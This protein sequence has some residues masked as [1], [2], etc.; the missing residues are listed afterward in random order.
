M[1]RYYDA[2]LAFI[3]DAGFSEWAERSAPGILAILT[4][5][6]IH[7]GLV[8]DLGC[9]PGVWARELS[10]N[11]FRV[12]GIDISEAM[13]EIA[14][15]R[16][17]EAEFRV[18]SFFS[19]KLPVCDAITS[20]SE[21]LN[22]VFDSNGRGGIGPVFDR[23]FK[24]LRPGGVFIFDLAEPGQVNAKRPPRNFSEGEGW[25]VLVEKHE[26]SKRSLL[27]RRIIAF[28]KSGNGYRRT[29]EV[30]H[31]RLY[32]PSEISRE[33]RRAGF[34]VRTLRG[35]GDYILPPRHRVFVA[36]KPRHRS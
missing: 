8:V 13:I 33:L 36:R 20:I 35:Y 29:E 4:R 18:A 17:P 22:Y 1:N 14:R 23:V 27:T 7:E 16:V 15:R 6:G 2:D 31:Q 25:T 11:G 19:A 24:A 10:N 3:H 26:D 21:C 28:R 30:H 34:R 9:G 5:N 32:R 12:L